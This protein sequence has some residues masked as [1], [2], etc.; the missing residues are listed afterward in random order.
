MGVLNSLLDK[1]PNEI[2]SEVTSPTYSDIQDFGL[3]FNS[4]QGID[5]TQW[6]P[7]AFPNLTSEVKTLSD[8]FYNSDGVKSES[9]TPSQS[10]ESSHE[11]EIKKECVLD[12]PPI[13]PNG[14]SHAQSPRENMETT[15]VNVNERLRN[16]ERPA[17]RLD[18]KSL[19][20][21][22]KL[23]LLNV[24]SRMKAEPKFGNVGFFTGDVESKTRTMERV[25]KMMESKNS[26]WKYAESKNSELKDIESKNSGLK[27]IESRKSEMRNTESKKSELR[28]TGTKNSELKNTESKKS[29]MRKTEGVNSELRNAESKNTGSQNTESKN[30]DSRNV[31]SEMA[32]IASRM[33]FGSNVT[34]L[35]DI[36]TKTIQVV[37]AR[38]IQNSKTPNIISKY[39]SNFK[40]NQQTMNQHTILNKTKRKAVVDSTG[41]NSPPILP[42][43]SLQTSPKVIVLDS[44]TPV[45][46]DP[47]TIEVFPPPLSNVSGCMPL[48]II[49]KKEPMVRPNVDPK[50]IKRQ[51]RM[52]KNRES[53]NLSRKKKK[54][55]LTSLEKQVQELLEENQQLKVE[56]AELKRR[57]SG[58][59]NKFLVSNFNSLSNKS[60]SKGFALC[61]FVFFIGLNFDFGR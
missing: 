4:L 12:T 35:D 5:V 9:P 46:I 37:K 61:L 59:T 6:G 16:F 23:Q 34:T 29:D 17:R 42:N 44:V 56:N 15:I 25:T 2:L 31:Q 7:E 28:N 32:A 45:P 49:I 11:F 57:L 41:K 24:H 52:I 8:D 10:S 47:R 20:L 22:E 50:I 48:P 3:D 38:S 30:R 13:S 43:V 53:A 21:D 54:E 18:V 40:M 58:Q 51:Q 1:S 26:E 19:N 27:N 36:N 55:Y 14:Y 33:K 39:A 60:L